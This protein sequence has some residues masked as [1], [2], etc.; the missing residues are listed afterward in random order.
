MTDDEFQRRLAELERR[1]LAI[2]RELSI[3]NASLLK[4]SEIRK[5]QAS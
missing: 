1:F 4:S 2:E 3:L 5:A